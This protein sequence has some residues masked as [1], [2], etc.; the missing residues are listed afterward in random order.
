MEITD[1][2]FWFLADDQMPR[3]PAYTSGNHVEAL[4]DGKAY[5]DH[6]NARMQ[7]MV[8]G[9]YFYLTGWRVSPKIS[10]TPD[11]SSRPQFIDQ[12]L[13]LIAAKVEVKSMVWFL[14]NFPVVYSVLKKA[15]VL[16][17]AVRRKPEAE[18]LDAGITFTEAIHK[19]QNQSSSGTDAILD[20]RL[21]E[22]R[23][24]SHHQKFILL[25]S[26]NMHQAYVGG[27]DIAVDRW[28]TPDHQSP[29]H[30]PREILDAWH[31]V[32]CFLKGAA[33]S[34]VFDVFA[35]R[36][37]ENKLGNALN[38]PSAAR[39]KPVT[40]PIASASLASVGSLNVQV[41]RTLVCGN[42]YDFAPRGEHTVALAYEKAISKAKHYIYIEDQYFWDCS[43]TPLLARKARE[44]VKII[45]VLAKSYDLSQVYMR[46]AHLEMRW[47]S[48]AELRKGEGVNHVHVFHLEKRNSRAQ[49]YVHSKVM[50]IDDCYAAIGSA[51]INYRS[52]TN[53]SELQIA[54]VDGQKIPGQMNGQTT[55]V[56]A[57]AHNFRKQL[58]GE[59]LGIN[60]LNDLTDPIA[61]LSKFPSRSIGPKKIHHTV[62]HTP[63]LK[64]F[65]TLEDAIEIIRRFKDFIPAPWPNAA[66]L[67]KLAEAAEQLDM[68]KS[69]VL[70]LSP[71]TKEI[72]KTL[73][74]SIAKSN[75]YKVL[76]LLAVKLAKLVLNLRTT[77]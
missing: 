73:I 23:P 57:F 69:G 58:W 63:D 15:P 44:G 29:S 45:L 51:N 16:L 2:E 46:I 42:V 8:A 33:V 26:E 13:K 68:D 20:A 12:V 53:D 62:F 65:P 39:P 17:W 36:W 66:E 72:L 52:Q 37:N 43:L 25:K 71:E 11:V 10:L 28:D 30:R 31:D 7:K 38:I 50:I 19:S 56:C 6:L 59:H 48:I 77:C 67:K 64:P 24:S 1:P 27:I 60:N 3:R 21:N 32:Q 70:T 55:Q 40:N 9:D 41:L 34:Q 49:I 22:N 47:D 76:E 75:G 4:V 74:T 14:S 35:Q 18:P 54:L 5:M 61:S